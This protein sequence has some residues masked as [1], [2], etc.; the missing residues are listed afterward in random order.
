M[1]DQSYQKII[2]K[3][4]VTKRV[5]TYFIAV[6]GGYIGKKIASDLQL[7]NKKKWPRQQGGD[8]ETD[9]GQDDSQLD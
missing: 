4:L 1:L 5:E 7:G 6:A 9:E 2:I 8:Q 3:E